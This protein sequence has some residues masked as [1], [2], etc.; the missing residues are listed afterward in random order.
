MK[1]T[2]IFRILGAVGLVLLIAYMGGIF[3]TDLISPGQTPGDERPAYR[4][5]ATAEAERT[6]ITETYEAV[7]TVRPLAESSV[8]AQVSGKIVSVRVRAGDNVERGDVL[9]VLEDREYQARL[10]QA[11]QGLNSA[12][13]AREQA[14]QKIEEA[15][16]AFDEATS[17]FQRIKT[18]YE[19][20]AVTQRE[21]DQAE[22]AFLQT[23]SRLQ[24]AKDGLSRAEADVL[25]A[26]KMV[27]EAQIAL[28]YTRIKAPEAGQVAQRLADPGDLA[29]PGKPLLVLQTPGNLRLEAYVREGLIHKV[30]PG[31]EFDVRIGS[32]ESTVDGVVTEVVPSAD[33]RTRTFLVKVGIPEMPGV[34]PGMF[35]RLLIP[36]GTRPAVLV[37][38]GAVRR[39]G[40][41][42]TV[43]VKEGEDWKTYYVK[44][45]RTMD[46]MV[47]V[48]SGLSGGETVAVPGAGNA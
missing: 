33:P 22:A 21:L 14:R 2:T 23:R 20:G 4:P 10:D 11:L 44:T 28:G 8:E 39:V 6:E 25:R 27:E 1:K 40:Q 17:Q 45:G 31:E 15:E 30:R 43:L 16:A 38:E 3:A 41:L 48:L 46:G 47:E 5:D 35:G 12:K 13:A 36:E 37:P 29:A 32:L 26:R 24:Q 9:V 7:G 19:S 18:L 42:E 34:H